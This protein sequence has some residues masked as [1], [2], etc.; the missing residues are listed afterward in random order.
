MRPS[1]SVTMRLACA[2]IRWARGAIRMAAP[3]R[4]GPREDLSTSRVLGALCGAQVADVVARDAAVA[5]RGAVEAGGDVEEGALAG[6][7]A[8]EDGD[9]IARRQIQRAPP[10]RRDGRAAVPVLLLDLGGCQD[11]ARRG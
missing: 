7:A 10:K 9:E 2:A 11:Q 6:A 3:S 4:V 5:A 1:A 8:A